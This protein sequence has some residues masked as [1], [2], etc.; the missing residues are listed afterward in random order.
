VQIAAALC[1][2]AY[3]V[4]QV[5]LRQRLVAPEQLGRMSAT[6]KTVVWGVM[7]VGALAGGALG[8]TIGIVPTICVGAVVMLSAIPWLFA[9]EIRALPRV[10]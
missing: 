5:S 6:M 8:S 1:V 7:P 9:S 3:N 4:T 2:P 10:A